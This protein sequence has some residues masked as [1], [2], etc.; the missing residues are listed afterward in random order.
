MDDSLKPEL[1]VK[2]GEGVN[3]LYYR[4]CAGVNKAGKTCGLTARVSPYTC[5]YQGCPRVSPTEK[6]EMWRCV[7]HGGANKLDGPPAPVT[8]ITLS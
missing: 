7:K 5:P 4:R 8:L 3:A 6:P 2:K 1:F